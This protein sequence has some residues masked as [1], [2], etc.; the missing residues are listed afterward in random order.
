MRITEAVR[1]DN[2]NSF[3]RNFTEYFQTVSEPGQLK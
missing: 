2:S 1:S 3:Q